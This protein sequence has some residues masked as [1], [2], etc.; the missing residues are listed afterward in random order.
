VHFLG[1]HDKGLLLNSLIEYR[2]GNLTPTG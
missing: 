1:M 2:G